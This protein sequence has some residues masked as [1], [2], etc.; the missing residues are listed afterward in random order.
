MNQHK[1]DITLTEIPFANWKFDAFCS[2]LAP[3]KN[4][5]IE[6]STRRN[7]FIEGNFYYG[8]AIIEEPT[9]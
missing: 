9:E 2:H 1:G 7:S 8:V 4:R 3:E 6:H 5:T